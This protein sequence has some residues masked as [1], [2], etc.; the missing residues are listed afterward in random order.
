MNDL[1]RNEF[2]GKN[3]SLE[4]KNI[5]ISSLGNILIHKVGWVKPDQAPYLVGFEV[6]ANIIC[7]YRAKTQQ[8]IA[9]LKA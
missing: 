9:C 5:S 8:D 1:L 2:A 4:K 6:L 7:A 3:A